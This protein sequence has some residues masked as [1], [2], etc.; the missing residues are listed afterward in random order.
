MNERM[1]G[2]TEGH[3][4]YLSCSSQLR[5]EDYDLKITDV[6]T[7]QCSNLDFLENLSL[8][9]LTSSQKFSIG[10]NRFD[11]GAFNPNLY[12]FVTCN[13]RLEGG[14]FRGHFGPTG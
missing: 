9:N 7:F 1:N 5:I 4:H 11:V 2:R 6:W 10:V 14:G 12:Y 8:G 13:L 3:G